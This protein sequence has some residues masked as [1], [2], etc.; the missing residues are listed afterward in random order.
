MI[1]GLGSQM[2]GLVQ[3]VETKLDGLVQAIEIKSDRQEH[4]LTWL[5]MEVC[6]IEDALGIEPTER[7]KDN[8]IELPLTAQERGAWRRK[9]QPENAPLPPPS[10]NTSEKDADG[11]DDEAGEGG[12]EM[13]PKVTGE[14]DGPDS[15][16]D[17]VVHDDGQGQQV[18]DSSTDDDEDEDEESGDTEPAVVI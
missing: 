15:D 3:A 5:Y 16:E 6:H 1:A 8:P 13:Q 4:F 14:E 2:D 10:L 18:V 17:G 12:Q 11:E 9:P 7:Q